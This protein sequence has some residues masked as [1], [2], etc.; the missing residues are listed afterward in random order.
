[1]TF[2]VFF[3]YFYAAVFTGN[4]YWIMLNG[5]LVMTSY[6]AD[7]KESLGN[8]Q[9]PY[10]RYVYELDYL[11]ILFISLCYLDE[12]NTNVFLLCSAAY[13]FFNTQSIDNVKNITLVIGLIKCYICCFAINIFVGLNLVGFSLIGI[14]VYIARKVYFEK[15]LINKDIVF[16]NFLTLIWRICALVI[17][18]SAS[19]TM[20]EMRPLRI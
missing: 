9:L 12:I 14:Y 10:A 1:M 15:N 3:V 4:F 20:E 13:E 2:W 18:L 7:I 11:C 19:C 6:L 17:L 16:Y 5:A 8:I